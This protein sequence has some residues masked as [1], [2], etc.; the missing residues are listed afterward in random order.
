[1]T[2]D[3]AVAPLSADLSTSAVDWRLFPLVFERHPLA[4][5]IIDPASGVIIDANPAAAQFYGYTLSD[6]RGMRLNVLNHLTSDELAERLAS[7]SRQKQVVFLLPHY[8]ASGETR[9]VESHVAAIDLDGQLR[10]F[11][12]IRDVTVEQQVEDVLH[13]GEQRFRALVQASPDAITVADLE[14]KTTFAGIIFNGVFDKFPGLRV[15]PAGPRSV[16]RAG[17]AGRA[18][19]DTRSASRLPT[20]VWKP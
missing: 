4:M 2:N 5:L 19:K 7:A 13:Q 15:A 9:L 14:G 17:A 8:L 16:D 18:Q 20:Y 11:N 6:M 3:P 10:L 12:I 1:M